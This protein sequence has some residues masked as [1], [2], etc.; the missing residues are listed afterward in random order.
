MPG[1]VAVRAALTWQGMS[2]A[3]P[4]RAVW[5]KIV[6]RRNQPV[7]SRLLVPPGDRACCDGPGD[8]VQTGAGGLVRLD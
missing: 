6:V 5:V 3:P 4:P 7:Q 1:Q 8:F 2:S